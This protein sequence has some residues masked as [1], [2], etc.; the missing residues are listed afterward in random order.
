MNELIPYD[1][2]LDGTIEHIF[3]PQVCE[4]RINLLEVVFSPEFY[5]S[6][7]SGEYESDEVHSKSGSMSIMKR[8]ILLQLSKRFT[9]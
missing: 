7:F 5:L 3:T 4:N 6:A 9:N 2:I 8:C 1:F